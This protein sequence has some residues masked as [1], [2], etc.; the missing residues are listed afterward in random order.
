MAARESFRWS[1]QINSAFA[2][3]A[4]T[5]PKGQSLT[6]AS[7]R[8]LSV[9]VKTPRLPKTGATR[10]PS[11]PIVSRKASTRASAPPLTAQQKVVINAIADNKVEASATTLESATL[12]LN[13][14]IANSM[15]YYTTTFESEDGSKKTYIHNEPTLEL[16]D[17]IYTITGSGFAWTETGW[18]DGSPTWTYGSEF[19]F[20]NVLYVHGEGRTARNRCL[21][22]FISVCQ[23]HRHSQTYIEY[24][25]S[26]DGEVRFALQVGTGIDREA[27]AF[28]YAK[29]YDM[30][31]INCAVVLD[32]GK[33]AIIE[34]MF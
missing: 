28:S 26:R 31:Q 3:I 1:R 24:Y 6:T 13:Q 14:L 19:I 21:K 32:S 18:N 27:Y 23:G 5:V 7:E 15:G 11:L 17:L 16:S 9:S 25:T 8:F 10:V 2:P 30:Q 34:P 12:A 20:D 33:Y 29:D 22:D 4:A